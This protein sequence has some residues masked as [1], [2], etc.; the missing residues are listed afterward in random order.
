MS[1]FLDVIPHF[2]KSASS[3]NFPVFLMENGMRSKILRS[4]ICH[5]QLRKAKYDLKLTW[6][7]SRRHFA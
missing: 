5:A 7:R 1:T 2:E 3:S 4:K 6:I